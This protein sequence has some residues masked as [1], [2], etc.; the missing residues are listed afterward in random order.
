M[1]EEEKKWSLFKEYDDPV[2]VFHNRNEIPYVSIPHL[3][4]QIEFCYNISGAEGMFIDKQLY[5]CQGHDLFLIPRTCVHKTLT[6]KDVYYERCIINIDPAFIDDLNTSKNLHRPLDWLNDPQ[7]RTGAKVNLNEKQHQEFISLVDRYQVKDQSDLLRFACLLQILDFLTRCFCSRQCQKAVL[8][9]PK[10]IAEQALIEIESH[11]RDIRVA[12]LSG[13]LY[14]SSSH[15]SEQFKEAY[16]V[17]LN[18]YLII[19]KIA[20]AKKYLYLG[21]PVQDVCELC[22]FSSYSNFIR[23]FKKYEGVSPGKLNNLTDP[24]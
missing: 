5:A 12:D 10:T 9:Q 14:I 18:Q 1:T 11:F 4:S 19:R 15:L 17:T 3:H 21:V 23:T 8:K 13:K 6:P 16:G 24:L 22:G 2:L 20:E 7:Y